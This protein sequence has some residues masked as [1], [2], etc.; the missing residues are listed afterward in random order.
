MDIAIILFIVVP[1]LIAIIFGPM[2]G[3]EDR[4]AFRWPDKKPRRNV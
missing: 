2:F 1:L 3:A 4:P